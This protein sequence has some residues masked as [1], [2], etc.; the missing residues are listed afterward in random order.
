MP[1]PS[2]NCA[3]WGHFGNYWTYGWDHRF[4][5]EPTMEG[6]TKVTQ[7]EHF[8]GLLVPF[9]APWLRENVLSGFEQMNLAL[10]NRVESTLT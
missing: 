9:F 3:G 1:R 6:L 5:I 7:S 8:S 4:E 10:K 2:E